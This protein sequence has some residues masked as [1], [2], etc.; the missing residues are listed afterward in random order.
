MRVVRGGK[1]FR[2]LQMWEA[3]SDVEEDCGKKPGRSADKIAQRNE[4][5]LYRFVWYYKDRSRNFYWI[6]EQLAED[7][8]L[9]E[10]T[11]GQLIED[12]ADRIK[13]IRRENLDTRELR[14]KFRWW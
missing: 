10:S 14:A 9:T 8:F 4:H 11:V 2:Q 7:Y 1:V 5:L 6:I 12:S 3:A 13:E